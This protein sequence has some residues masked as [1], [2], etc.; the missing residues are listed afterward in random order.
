MKG[1][2]LNFY[3]FSPTNVDNSHSNGDEFVRSIVWSTFDRLE[4][5]DIIT[6]DEY[7]LSKFSEKNWIGERQFA[8]IYE[9]DE[10]YNSL[11]Y[12]KEQ[13]DECRFVFDALKNNDR[14]RFFGVTL[15]DFTP[16]IH[17][18]FYGCKDEATNHG[19]LIRKTISNAIEDVID[20][21]SI[22]QEDI[23][24]E[25]FGI[26]G[27][28]DVVIIWLANQFE[29]IARVIEGL[30]K[31][32][33][34][35]NCQVI[36]NVYTTIGLKDVNNKKIT[37]NDINGKLHIKL[38]KRD[39]FDSSVFETDL[40]KIL[41]KESKKRTYYT[42]FGEHDLM[43]SI[44]GNQLVS[45]LYERDGVFNSKSPNFIKNFIQSKTEITIDIR[46]DEIVGC[47]FPINVPQSKLQKPSQSM[48]NEYV[49]KIDTI[50]KSDCFSKASYL[51][52]T[53]WLLYE[54]FLKN[55]MSSFSYPWTNDLD[56]QFENCLNYLVAVVSSE[57]DNDK[58]YENIH[59]L[60]SSM[61]QMMLHIAQANRI[62]FEIPN[63]HLK[64]TGAYSKILHTYYGVVKQYLKLSYS[65]PKYDKQSPIVPFISFDVTPITKSR[66]C[67]NV[68]GFNNKIIR[69]ELPYEALINI[70][71]Y[72]KLLAHE[73]YH[74]IA[75]ADRVERNMLIATLSL[76]TIMGQMI[77]LFFKE[78]IAISFSDFPTDF[79]ERMGEEIIS[80][81]NKFEKISK[82]IQTEILNS[83]N[84]ADKFKV[85]I[86]N[87]RDNAEWEDY[88][89][90]FS[91]SI[92]DELKKQSGVT[93]LLWDLIQN[94]ENSDFVDDSL[95]K[96]VSKS[97]EYGNSKFYQWI[98]QK[99]P[100][101]RVNSEDV[102]LRYSLREALADHFMIQVTEMSIVEYIKYVYEYQELVSKKPE[103]MRQ[104]FRVALVINHYLGAQIMDTIDFNGKSANDIYCEVFGWINKEYGLDDKICEWVGKNYVEFALRYDIYMKLFDRYFMLLDFATYNQEEYYPEFYQC[105]SELKN[106]MNIKYEKEFDSNIRYIEEFQNQEELRNLTKGIR[107]EP[108]SKRPPYTP[109]FGTKYGTSVKENGNV[110]TVPYNA[111]NITELISAIKNAITEIKGEEENVPIWFRGHES[112]RYLLIPSL[113]RMKNKRDLFYNTSMRLTMQ[114]LI[115]LF[116]AKA[117]NAPELIG[118]GTSFNTNCMITMQ[119]YSI[120]TNILDWTTSAFVAMYFAL[121][122][123]INNDEDKVNTDAVIYLLNPIRL[124]S[125]REKLLHNHEEHGEKEELRFPITALVND[126][127]KFADYVPIH[128]GEDRV[129]KEHTEYPIAIYAPFVNQRIKAQLGTFTIFGLDNKASSITNEEGVAKDYSSFSLAEVQKK[130]KALCEKYKGTI[131]YKA[132]LT[133]VRIAADAKQEI[134]ENLRSL[135]IGKNN[136]YPEL[137]NISNEITK[138]VK[139]YFDLNK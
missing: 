70:T 25:I 137:E 82:I 115:D 101:D 11:L 104:A 53:L 62:F 56:Y 123:E 24:Y 7:R 83:P 17:Q 60:I 84:L 114:S 54:D 42:L 78:C 49:S 16:E 65:I 59:K 14:M 6:F 100:I 51:Q 118:D 85:W 117:Y 111:T 5:R 15:I 127:K 96:L 79:D 103:H 32:K 46:Y 134:A 57:I 136:I 47:V 58:K 71:K 110:D 80:W 86:I 55:I 129:I 98:T 22:S 72:I 92:A 99:R 77:K 109:D 23:A 30:R 28:Q 120:P 126:D 135:G 29:D 88:F 44:K 31:S 41:G 121:E 133:E 37:Y 128:L 45:A 132:F 93:E 113:Y 81:E 119:H 21:N 130:Y 90:A 8:M 68:E 138:E 39:S 87:Y 36:A 102:D 38:T 9:L 40:D 73:I 124:N 48:I 50:A 34:R 95:E 10:N 74:Y 89:N 105:F 131:E 66:F 3:K 69:I 94:L 125:A 13:D 1:Y 33:T 2:L 116:K 76:A 97:K 91:R 12:N 107:N 20:K 139:A 112:I 67:D 61:R 43:I 18:F 35:D 19:A 27:G 52:E 64:H 108:P 122:K 26:L 63:T 4:V 106:L 75:P